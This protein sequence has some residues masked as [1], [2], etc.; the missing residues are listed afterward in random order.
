MRSVS[1]VLV[2][3]FFFSDVASATTC[4]LLDGA[5]VEASDGTYLGFFGASSATD[6]IANSSSLYG[7]QA[8]VNSVRNSSG[9]YGSS[10]GLNSA[11][12]SVSLNPPKIYTGVQFLGF[13][14]TN[15]TKSPRVE[16]ETAVSDC[17]FTKSTP[18]KVDEGFL[19]L[20]LNSS[21]SISFFG[22]NKAGYKI[23]VVQAGILKI[24]VISPDGVN[25]RLY[26]SSS[27][28][29]GGVDCSAISDCDEAAFSFETDGK[30]INVAVEEG[31]KEKAEQFKN[32]GAEIYK[33]I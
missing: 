29:L 8:G 15:T 5:Y 22:E 23:D 11:N 12:N 6:S 16:V 24:N 26:N 9:L 4:D 32:A 28:L 2:L 20:D 17:S 18:K 21:T 25:Y 10:S 33:P 7:S 31:M 19:S 1:L 27:V 13:L 3:V 30:D 14:S